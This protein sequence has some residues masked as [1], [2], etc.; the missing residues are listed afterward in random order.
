MDE[1]LQERNR[2]IALL[3]A[4]QTVEEV[5][6]QLKRSAGWVR[7]WRGRFRQFG[8][9]GLN[10]RSRAPNQVHNKTPVTLKEA[11]IT[12][13]MVLEVE[14]ESGDGLKYIGAPAV[15]TRLRKQDVSPL[16]SVPTIERILRGARL[17]RER[18]K[19][20]EMPV[21]YPHLRPQHAHELIQVDIL[22]HYLEG[23]QRIACFNG[24]D[25]VSRYPTG[26]A[27]EQR[28]AVDAAHFLCR[29]WQEMGVPRYTQV[30]NE[31]CFSGGATHA[32]VLGRVV[33][34]AL[35][36]GTELVFSPT[37]HPESNGHVERFHQDYNRHVWE[38]TYLGSLGQVNQQ[39][40]RFFDLYRQ[41]GHHS[42]LNGDTPHDRHFQPPPAQEIPA[43]AESDAK[44]PLYAG[45]VHFM[46]RVSSAK[47]VR[48]LNVD[49]P[50]SAPPDTGVWATLSLQPSEAWVRIYDQAPDVESRSCMDVHP[51]P[52]REPVLDRAA[53]QTPVDD[54]TP[55]EQSGVNSL[56]GEV[57]V[58]ALRE[59]DPE[60]TPTSDER[61]V[62]AFP[63]QL[64]FLASLPLFQRT[65]AIPA[66]LTNQRLE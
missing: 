27:Y 46:R 31:G 35:A 15:R 48:V 45:H 16:P 30:D 39:A 4:G 50:V 59:Q 51:F 8:Y 9:A 32:Y 64:L 18:K 10:G 19:R 42:A 66:A 34:L 49:W 14:A 41:S 26:H 1:L 57:Q 28:R 2:A 3:Q 7:K 6:S 37:Y 47:T 11:V 55:A 53:P 17:T 65:L 52:L 54:T 33:R 60:S 43:V 63:V 62:M 24:I 29:L 23:G 56:P 38:D 40:E 12:A 20:Q 21:V 5:A 22:P 44:L 58:P 61:S 13:R 25:V 36:V